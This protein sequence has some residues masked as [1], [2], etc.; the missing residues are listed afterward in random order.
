MR[1]TPASRPSPS[2]PDARQ[3]VTSASAPSAPIART[4]ED[5]LWIEPLS[6]AA[7]AAEDTE[8]VATRGESVALAFAVYKSEGGSDLL[9]AHGVQVLDLAE[10]SV[11]SVVT[12]LDPALVGRFRLAPEIAPRPANKSRLAR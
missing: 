1:R 9:H 11:R 10:R 3:L 8:S 7:L 12:F 4:L 5:T 2:A 6:D